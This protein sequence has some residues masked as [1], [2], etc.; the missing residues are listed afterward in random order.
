[1]R[2]SLHV[3]VNIFCASPLNYV[4]FLKSEYYCIKMQIRL[5]MLTL[6]CLPSLKYVR[7]HIYYPFLALNLQF[8]V[9][10]NINYVK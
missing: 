5:Q 8:Y 6:P 7:K 10:K 9:L 4:N 3:S 2:E 1:M